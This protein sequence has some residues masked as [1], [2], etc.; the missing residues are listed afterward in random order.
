MSIAKQQLT[1]SRESMVNVGIK[2]IY[3][4]HLL[5]NKLLIN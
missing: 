2:L 3:A 4:M 1:R 5:V